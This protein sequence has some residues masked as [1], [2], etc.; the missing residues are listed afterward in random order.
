[1]DVVTRD[2]CSRLRTVLA[3]NAGAVLGW[4]DLVLYALFAAVLGRVSFPAVDPNVSL[5]LSLGA[6]AIS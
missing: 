3:A 5:L 4:F 1:M 2:P 6:F